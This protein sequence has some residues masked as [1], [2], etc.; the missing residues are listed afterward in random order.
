MLF[1]FY[2]KTP[3]AEATYAAYAIG[4]SDVPLPTLQAVI[5]R[6][7]KKYKVLP[8]VAEI[9]AEYAGDAD[10]KFLPAP[11]K[12]YAERDE[13][14][15]SRP[16]IPSAEETMERLKNVPDY[17]PTGYTIP[18]ESKEERLERLRQ[19]KDWDRRY[20]H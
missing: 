2:P 14:R 9:L 3:V 20:D 5:V 15:E 6:C 11:P 10:T 12:T 13:E 4:L 19:T 17:F 16:Y 1:A 18:R 7:A 8:S